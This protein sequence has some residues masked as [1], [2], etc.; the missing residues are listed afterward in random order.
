[1]KTKIY[2]TAFL[3]ALASFATLAVS[4]TAHDRRNNPMPSYE[5]QNMGY[6]RMGRPRYDNQ[7]WRGERRWSRSSYGYGERVPPAWRA[8]RGRIVQI[9]RGRYAGCFRVQRKG[10]YQRDPAIIT[11]RYCED[12]YGQPRRMRGTKRLVRYTRPMYDSYAY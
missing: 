5:R 2:T 4:A 12:G 10:R 8:V 9:G 1:M 3:L 6:A 7:R 11:I